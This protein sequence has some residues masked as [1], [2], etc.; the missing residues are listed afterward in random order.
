[1][2][3]QKQELELA[4]AKAYYGN[5]NGGDDTGDDEGDAPKPVASETTNTKLFKA[6]I[7]TKTEYQRLSNTERRNG[8][9]PS[10]YEDYI[11]ETL[12]RWLGTEKLA[13]EEVAYLK[14][15]YGI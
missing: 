9:N 11:K 12:N 1:M 4:R 14:A 2:A 15:Y 3:L 10:S 13:P 8:G 5:D 7:R 6:S